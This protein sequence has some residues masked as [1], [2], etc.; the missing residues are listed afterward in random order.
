[1]PLHGACALRQ[2]TTRNPL[3]VD[4]I[5]ALEGC[6]ADSC[7]HECEGD[8]GRAFTPGRNAWAL[9]CSKRLTSVCE[10]PLRKNKTAVRKAGSG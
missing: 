9:H 6:P 7:L 8:S 10:F 2:K 3:C 4:G 1:M 5:R